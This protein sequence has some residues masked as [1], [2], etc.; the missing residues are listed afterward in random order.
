MF[1][2]FVK[3]ARRLFS[4]KSNGGKQVPTLTNRLHTQ[5]QVLLAISIV[6]LIGHAQFRDHFL[7]QGIDGVKAE[8]ATNFCLINGTTTVLNKNE[9]TPQTV[10]LN[11]HEITRLL[12]F[13]ISRNDVTPFLRGQPIDWR[14]Y[15]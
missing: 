3:E 11:A 10:S 1:D 13:R 7:C 5:K 9:S 8:I 6:L 2:E 4:S 14:S 12:S 15:C